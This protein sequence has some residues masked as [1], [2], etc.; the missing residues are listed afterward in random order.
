MV[1]P[2][3]IYCN[4]VWGNAA[5]SSIINLIHLQKRAVRLITHSSYRVSTKLLFK[6][7]RILP[8]MDLHQLHV[9]L[10]VYRVRVKS[11]PQTCLHHIICLDSN[12]RN[13][14]LRS[15]HTII[16]APARTKIREKYIGVAGT[17]L[18]NSLPD[19]VTSSSSVPEF[20]RNMITYL[21]A[22]VV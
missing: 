15:V 20:K 8:L 12:R 16:P 6:Q 18:W 14:N 2:Y 7:L 4:I 9:G 1:Q 11:L 10:F 3:L 17:K 19:I 21:N 5:A 22:L 13:Y